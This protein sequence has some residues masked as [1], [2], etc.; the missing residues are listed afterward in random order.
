MILSKLDFGDLI[1]YIPHG[2]YVSTSF[3]IFKWHD[4]MYT[5]KCNATKFEP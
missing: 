5:V 2:E 1:M 3:K 4:I